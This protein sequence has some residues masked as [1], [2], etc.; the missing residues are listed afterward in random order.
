MRTLTAALQQP[1]ATTTIHSNSP[2]SMNG[3]VQTTVD[4]SNHT[5]PL[6]PRSSYTQQI[7]SPIFNTPNVTPNNTR[8]GF[9]PFAVNV[10]QSQ[11]M[12]D[13]YSSSVYSPMSASSPYYVMPSNNLLAEH[14]VKIEGLPAQHGIAHSYHNH[15][16]MSHMPPHSQSQSRSPSIDDEHDLQSQIVSRNLERPSVVNIKKE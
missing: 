9:L 8:S 1:T 12:S 15:H 2:P 10:N 6:S 4:S 13:M 3:S 16:Q 5:P 14:E 7:P 11:A